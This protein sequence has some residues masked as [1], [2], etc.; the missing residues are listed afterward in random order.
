MQPTRNLIANIDTI[1][2]T[3]LPTDNIIISNPVNTNPNLTNL[4]KL[5]PN[6][7]GIARKNVNSAATSLD[8]PINK[9]PNIVAPEREVP[10]KTAAI[11]W[12]NPIITAILKVN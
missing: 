7:T 2:A 1:N 10:G 3:I 5:A 6:I 4:S 8:T 9:A 11:T 12:N